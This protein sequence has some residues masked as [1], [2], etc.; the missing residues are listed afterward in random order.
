MTV[1]IPLIE[2]GSTVS[3]A[4]DSRL[5]DIAFKLIKSK[6]ILVVT[7]AGVSCNAGIPVSI[8]AIAVCAKTNTYLGL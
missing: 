7:G 6:K 3:T 5:Q 8:T 4:D 2:R 1:T